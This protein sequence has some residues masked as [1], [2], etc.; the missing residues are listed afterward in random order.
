MPDWTPRQWLVRAI[1]PLAIVLVAGGF[2]VNEL[3]RRQHYTSLEAIDPG[4]SLPVPTADPV[5]LIVLENEPAA[6][7]TGSRDAPYLNE[8]VQ[9]SAVADD[10][11][12][13]A[14]PSQPNYIAL[15]SGAIHDVLDDNVHQL[16]APNLADQVEA[17]RK[18]WRV[19]AENYPA[20]GC[21]D[22]AESSD[23]PDG[24]GLY[25]RKHNP[26]MSFT[27]ISADPARCA[28][29]QPLDKFAPEAANLVWVVPN[30]C[31]TMHDCPVATG[32]AW[33][34]SFVPPILA[35]PAFQPGGHGV[36]FVTFDEGTDRIRNNEVVTLAAGPLVKAG[37]RSPVAHSHYSL[38]RTI[39]TALGLPCL[40]DACSANT[41][42]E[43][44]TAQP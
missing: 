19:F 6:Y 42:G 15:F 44:F 21:F 41:L 26:A 10:Y 4:S 18:T 2:G 38:T 30:M 11:Q 31:H 39:E 24:P 3:L 8:L 23:G 1:V 29:I 43:M 40:A 34:R 37:F 22:G 25:T 27:S 13:V 17:A 36:L 12:A 20:T 14:H 5:I 32:D 16:S 35:S 28:N 9:S 33:L 7:I